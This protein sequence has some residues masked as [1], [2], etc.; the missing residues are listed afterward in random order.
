MIFLSKNLTN[1]ILYKISIFFLFLIKSPVTFGARKKCVFFLLTGGMSFSPSREVRFFG[2]ATQKRVEFGALQA[3]GDVY[4][5]PNGCIS[6]MTI[7]VRT[8]MVFTGVAIKKWPP[9]ISLDWDFIQ[10]SRISYIR[11]GT[12]VNL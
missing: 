7:T 12:N 11:V 2:R 3:K 4:G 8:Y 10:S 5:V 1:L 6:D 9:G